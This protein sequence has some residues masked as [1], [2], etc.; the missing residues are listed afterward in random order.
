MVD[1]AN[2]RS[3][4]FDL[5]G[6]LLDSFPVHFEAYKV[7][8]ASFKIEMS[9][10]LFLRTYSPNW[11]QTYEAFGLAKDHWDEANKIWLEEAAKHEAVLFPGVRKMLGELSANAPLGI[12]TSGSKSRVIR[13]LERTAI[14]HHFTAVI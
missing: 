8:F 4:V 11:Y 2:V 6:T 1:Y 13:D 3:I 10:E 9:R 7:V 14:G 5:D 12:V